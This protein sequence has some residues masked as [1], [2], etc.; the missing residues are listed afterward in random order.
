[1]TFI[2]VLAQVTG[3]VALLIL[4]TAPPIVGR[5]RLVQLRRHWRGRLRAAAPSLL[6]LA[7]ILLINRTARQLVPE[8]SWI[9]GFRITGQI[10]GIE[11]ALVAWLQSFATPMMTMYFTYVYVYGYVYLLV[12]PLVAYLALENP[13]PIRE[14]ALA[15]TFNYGIGLVCYVLFVAYGPRNMMPDLVDSLLIS[16]WPQ[17]ALL[18]TEINVNTN[19]FPSLHTSLSVTVALLAYRTRQIYPLW[20]VI[21]IPL[22]ASIVGATMYIGSHWAIDVIAGIGLAVIS[23]ALAKRVEIP[24]SYGELRAQLGTVGAYVRRAPDRVR[25]R[26]RF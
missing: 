4:L 11:G 16:S 19:V 13:R 8:L 2:A 24:G 15:Y 20:T 7:A 17:A 6:I 22:A 25:R 21:A 1:M 18:I 26:I 5:Y 12:F 3:V 10:Y 23:V 9:V 14:T